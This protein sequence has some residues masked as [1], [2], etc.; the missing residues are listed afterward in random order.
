MTNRTAVTFTGFYLKCDAKPCNHVETV[1]AIQAS[2]IGKPCP[3]CG[4]NL[5]TQRDFDDMQAFSKT[6]DV[7]NQAFPISEHSA[8][9]SLGMLSVNPH[10]G[11]WDVHLSLP[12]K[13]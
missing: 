7:I 5:L 10:N 6:M 11:G 4:E 3:K 2:D 9:G 13:E 1:D 12:E 8:T